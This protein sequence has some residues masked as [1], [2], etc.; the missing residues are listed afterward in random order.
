MATPAPVSVCPLGA[1]LGEGPTWDR[2]G[3]ALWFVDIKRLKIHRFDP[4]SGQLDSWNAPAQPGWLFPAGHGTFVAGLQTGIHRFDPCDGSFALLADP[5]PDRPNNRLND[6]A[7]APDGAIWLG[8]MDDA[9]EAATGHLYRFDGA[10]ARQA[11]DPMVITNGPAFSPDGGTLYFTDTRERT[12]WAIE[13]TAEGLGAKR[14]LARIEPGAGYPDGPSVDAEG[15]VWTGLFGGWAVRRYSPAG[16][17]M[18]EIRFPVA[19]VTKIVFGDTD[20]RTVYATTARKGLDAA[21]LA[22]QPLAGNLF[23]FRH[24]VSGLPTPFARTTNA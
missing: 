1:T 22:A 16:A 24:D 20:L 14:V 4:A 9:E 2:A 5:E 18:E 8:T 7:V 19:N 11:V 23:A 6:A 15:C 10:I 3:A 17:L 13:V 21:A 12:I